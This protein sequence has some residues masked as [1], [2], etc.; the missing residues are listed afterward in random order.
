MKLQVLIACAAILCGCDDQR[1]LRLRALG[2][3]DH[4]VEGVELQRSGN[5]CGAA[6][7]A[8]V[9]RDTGTRMS[10]EE[11]GRAMN[12]TEGGV[13]LLELKRAAE[14]LGYRAV[15]WR[16]DLSQLRHVRC[17][18]I[19]FIEGDHFVVMDSV[20]PDQSIFL[21]DPAIGRICLKA[22]RLSCIWKGEVLEVER[23][24]AAR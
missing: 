2:A 9:C 11:I 17:P 16:C 7:L 21:R 10:A 24:S 12:W 1:I 4:G 13:S 20:A 23:D 6:C 3:E 22:R 14:H 18:A 8:M 15:G 19:L 5:D